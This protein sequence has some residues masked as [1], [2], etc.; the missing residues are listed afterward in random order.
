MSKKLFGNQL[1]VIIILETYSETYF[2]TDL[3]FE[4][5]NLF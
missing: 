2:E 1:K 5:Q 3:E 4:K